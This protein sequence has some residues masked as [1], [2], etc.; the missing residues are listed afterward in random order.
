MINLTELSLQNPFG[1]HWN[2]LNKEN[3]QEQ[4][5]TGATQ[6]GFKPATVSGMFPKASNAVLDFGCGIGRNVDVLRAH[7]H[8]EYMIGYDL[9][10]MI[11]LMPLE[12]KVRYDRLTSEFDV[13]EEIKPRVVYASLCFQHIPTLLLTKYFERLAAWPCLLYVL[14]RRYNDG[15][16]DDILDMISCHFNAV[17]LSQ[18]ASGLY[19]CPGNPELHWSGIFAPRVME[20]PFISLTSL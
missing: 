1:Q 3:V 5:L 20:K 12:T 15:D 17:W 19:D 18:D 16:K 8:P 4:I 2:S 14:T 6:N 7:F 10:N 9:P 13:I 11:N